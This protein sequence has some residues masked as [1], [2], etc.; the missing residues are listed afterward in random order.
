MICFINLLTM[1]I[2]EENFVLEKTENKNDIQEILNGN[3]P[4]DTVK[5]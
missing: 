2:I 4:E 5:R 1:K 3:V